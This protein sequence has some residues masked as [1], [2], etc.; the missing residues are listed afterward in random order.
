MMAE[1][2]NNRKKYDVTGAPNHAKFGGKKQG[3]SQGAKFKPNH[4]SKCPVSHL[5]GGCQY[6][7]IPYEKQLSE[8]QKYIDD[9]LGKFGPVDKIIGM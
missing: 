6:V 7:D 2:K 5:C 8:K 3:R 9:L 1:R 4:D